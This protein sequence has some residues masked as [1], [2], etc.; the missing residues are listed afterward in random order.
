MGRVR[1]E[2]ELSRPPK[3]IEPD[4]ANA[5]APK[6]WIENNFLS[7]FKYL[8]T[9]AKLVTEINRNKDLY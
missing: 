1:R 6:L 4:G 9:T 3:P 7:N 2:S 5:M 8:I